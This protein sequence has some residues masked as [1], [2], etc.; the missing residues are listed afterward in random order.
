MSEEKGSLFDHFIMGYLKNNR[1]IILIFLKKLWDE[2][3][4]WWPKF[5]L[6]NVRGYVLIDA[7]I[8][9][10]IFK[11]HDP[12]SEHIIL[13]WLIINSIIIY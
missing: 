10:L 3:I 8:H 13:D 9:L 5:L 1:N 11:E 4:M 6:P 12:I 2:M 7:I